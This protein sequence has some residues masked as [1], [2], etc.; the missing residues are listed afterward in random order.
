MAKIGLNADHTSLITTA[1]NHSSEITEQT[2][3]ER[4]IM[5]T[6]NSPSFHQDVVLFGPCGGYP[7]EMQRCTTHKEKGSVWH[8][9]TETEAETRWI[10]LTHWL[11]KLWEQFWEATHVKWVKWAPGKSGGSSFASSPTKVWI[12]LP[13]LPRH[14]KSRCSPS[15]HLQFNPAHRQQHIQLV[16]LHKFPSTCL[17][18]EAAVKSLHMWIH[19]QNTT[20]LR[21]WRGL[22][23]R[24]VSQRPQQEGC[25]D[26]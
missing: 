9:D 23:S 1:K 10:I 16:K 24:T 21:T 20:R 11:N 12:P 22:G 19:A 2:A 4:S 18:L 26:S 8:T 13:G 17:L 25:C 3:Q 14:L 5:T 15:H 7:K 6:K